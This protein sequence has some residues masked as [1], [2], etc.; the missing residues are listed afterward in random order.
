MHC[1]MQAVC[2][3]AGRVT[4]YRVMPG[5]PG[6]LDCDALFDA[7]RV[8]GGLRWLYMAALDALGLSF[9]ADLPAC[10]RRMM[11]TNTIMRHLPPFWQD[12]DRLHTEAAGV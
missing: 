5:W 2:G 7:S 4:A 1:R 8:W 6:V 12:P 10:A 11:D 9:P 3:A